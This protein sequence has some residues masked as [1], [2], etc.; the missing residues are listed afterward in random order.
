MINLVSSALHAAAELSEEGLWSLGA[1]C[2]LA[3]RRQDLH[4]LEVELQLPSHLVRS[5]ASGLQP[6]PSAPDN[7]MNH[8]GNCLSLH[9]SI[10]PELTELSPLRTGAAGKGS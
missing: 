4:E 6:E 10:C 5:A 8:G 3:A 9:R 7:A 2:W 1:E